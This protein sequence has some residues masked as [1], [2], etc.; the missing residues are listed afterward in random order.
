MS[1]IP[2]QTFSLLIV[3]LVAVQALLAWTVLWSAR[4]T[5]VHAW[6]TGQANVIQAR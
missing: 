5:S 2:E 4:S 1:G 6:C 3:V